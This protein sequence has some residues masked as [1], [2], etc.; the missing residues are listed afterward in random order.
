MS[1]LL[2]QMYIHIIFHTK[3]NKL[4]IRD[5]EAEELYRYTGGIT[6]ETGSVPIKINGMSDHSIE[7]QKVHHKQ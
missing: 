4:I 7:N 1:Q 2:S 3:N 6:K 5:S